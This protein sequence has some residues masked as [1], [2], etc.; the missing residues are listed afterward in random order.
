MRKKKVL[1]LLPSI[2][3]FSSS[4]HKLSLHFTFLFILGE[5][6]FLFF[7]CCRF[8]R[9]TFLLHEIWG[10]K[11][12]IDSFLVWGFILLSKS[13]VVCF[14]ILCSSL[15]F[16]RNMLV[17]EPLIILIFFTLIPQFLLLLPSHFVI[18]LMVYKYVQGY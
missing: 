5:L 15:L 7:P 1:W 11:K 6:F 14:R 13:L 16:L 17:C 18:F 4:Q 8:I 10:T 3:Y 2:K 9:L 12:L